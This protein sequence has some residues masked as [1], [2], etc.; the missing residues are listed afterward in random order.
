MAT[1]VQ[2]GGSTPRSAGARMMITQDD[3]EGTVGGGALE[4]HVMDEA[5]QLLS[6][7]KRTTH[8]V[9]VHL[10]RD[11][12]MCCGGK[13]SVF[14][15]KVD[16]GPTLWIFGAGHVGT[17]LAHIAALTGFAVQI[18]DERDEWADASRFTD[19]VTV[20]DVDPEDHIRANPP[21]PDDYVVVVTHN[22]ALD[23]TLLRKLGEHPVTY[24]GMIGSRGKWLRFKDRLGAR[25]LDDAAHGSER[26]QT[27]AS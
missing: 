8:M 24:L 22:H 14:L 3:F 25:G 4:H 20:I 16:P 1:V 9:S 2:A 10:V 17:E 26:H 27:A 5:R 13:M 19:A 23:E 21:S 15:E 7:P 12:A 6:D 18:V 11:L